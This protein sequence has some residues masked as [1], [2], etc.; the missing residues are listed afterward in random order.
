MGLYLV[1]KV[2]YQHQRKDIPI[3]LGLVLFKL[4][5]GRP[6]IGQCIHDLSPVLAVNI[7]H[8]GEKYGE[9]A[10]N[11]SSEWKC[12][13]G[14]LQPWYDVFDEEDESLFGNTFGNTFLS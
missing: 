2:T 3:H 5:C 11:F 4:C 13:L 12:P 1:S 10:T 14:V 6:A 8:H 7:T 9:C